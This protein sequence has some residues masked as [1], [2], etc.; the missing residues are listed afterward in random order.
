[1][2]PES[3]SRPAS[4]SARSLLISESGGRGLSPSLAIAHTLVFISTGGGKFG[5]TATRILQFLFLYFAV[6]SFYDSSSLET[7]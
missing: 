7:D 3:N 5:F 4:E 1:M 6:L 2:L